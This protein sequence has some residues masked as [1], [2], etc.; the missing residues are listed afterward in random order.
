MTS[1]WS[2]RRRLHANVER[3]LANIA[4]DH[5]EAPLNQPQ[6]RGMMALS[7]LISIL[8]FFRG[9]MLQISFFMKI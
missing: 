1:Y 5:D 2:K 8:P 7:P 3:H 6:L 4:Q 9:P